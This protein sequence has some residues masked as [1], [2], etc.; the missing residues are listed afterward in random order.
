MFMMALTW[1]FVLAETFHIPSMEVARTDDPEYTDRVFISTIMTG[2]YAFVYGI[3]LLIDTH[4]L[5]FKDFHNLNRKDYLAAPMLFYID[6]IWIFVY[7]AQLCG[8]KK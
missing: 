3:Y 6:A 1:C 4:L 8:G 5:I 7:L 2:I